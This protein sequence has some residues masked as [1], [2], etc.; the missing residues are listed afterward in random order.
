MKRLSRKIF[1]FAALTFFSILTYAEEGVLFQ[2]NHIKGAAVSH[3]ATVEEEAY[4]NGRLNNRT[5][6]INRTSTTVES[7]EEDGTAL[8]FTHYMTTQNNFINSTGKTLSWGE[9]DSVRIFRDKNG[10][11]HDSDNQFLPTVQSIPSFSDKP[12]KIGE[13]WTSEGLEVH[14]CRELF[15]MEGAIEVPFTATYTYTGNEE[16][17][18]RELC[19]I[20]V[21]YKFFQ[22]GAEDKDLYDSD[23]Y[24]Y[25]TGNISTYAGTQGQAVQKIWWD[26]DK[27]ELDHYSEEFI[28]YLYDTY[29]NTFAFRGVAHGEVTEYKSV[30]N[31]DNLKKLQKKVEKYKLDNISVKQGDK[32]L[33]IS[34]DAIQFEPDS[35]VLLPS[36]KKKLEKLGEI[37]K[38]F[39]NDLLITGHCAQRGTVSAQQKLSEERAEAVASYL[40]ELGIRDHYHVF[41]QG[42]GAT[43]PVAS[44]AT[45]AGRI[46]NR[47]VEITIMD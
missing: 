31:K 27:G 37:L 19:V 30:N 8:L 2:F 28:I 3:V 35:D 41:T 22:G 16:L 40:V 29:N 12:V 32:G 25:G 44:N 47:R 34:L 39:A 14:D 46:K 42:K 7:V 45:E 5:Q 17:D 13:S 43:E 21:Q 38:E 36:E 10:H 33:T 4:I 18:G 15:N 11:L 9:E 24:L 20:E 6:F 23:M 26:N 1:V